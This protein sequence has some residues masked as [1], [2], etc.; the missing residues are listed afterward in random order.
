MCIFYSIYVHTRLFYFNIYNVYHPCLLEGVYWRCYSDK[1]VWAHVLK[2][3]DS[4]APP[5]LVSGSASCEETPEP[6]FE[7]LWTFI[8]SGPLLPSL[9]LALKAVSSLRAFSRGTP[10][11]SISRPTRG[12]AAWAEALP[13]FGRDKEKEALI[14]LVRELS[15]KLEL[16]VSEL[17]LV[18]LRAWCLLSATAARFKASRE[19]LLGR[20]SASLPGYCMPDARGGA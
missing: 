11:V 4:P 9:S 10:Y 2:C 5:R 12:C 19:E 6:R 3:S 20:A 18:C 8:C 14:L 16:G 1:K 7:P 15:T 13:T 17:H